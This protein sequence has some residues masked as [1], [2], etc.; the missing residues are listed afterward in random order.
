MEFNDDIDEEND[1]PQFLNFDNMS[2]PSK[3]GNNE[4]N[5]KNKLSLRMKLIIF[6]IIIIIIILI[7]LIIYFMQNPKECPSR[8]FLPDDSKSKCQQC[9]LK[10]CDKCFGTK[11]SN[12]CSSCISNFF[13]FYEN[14]ILKSCNP[15][16]IGKED[17][18]LA[19]DE[20]INKCAK[21]NIGYK[22]ENG[23]CILNYSFR[24]IYF[25]NSDKQVN[26][27]HSNYKDKIKEI[28]IDEKITNKEGTQR[29]NYGYH[30]VYILLD[31]NLITETSSMFSSSPDIEE[32]YFSSL[33]NNIDIKS[34][35]NMFS[36]CK[37]LTSIDFS[38][39]KIK[40]VTSLSGTFNGCSLLKNINISNIDISKVTSMSNMFSGCNKLEYIEFPKNETEEL[41]NI[42]QMFS[43]CSSLKSLELSNF[44]TKQATSFESLFKECNSLISLNISSFNTTKVSKMNEMFKD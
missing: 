24:A 26:L 38:N 40:N 42:Q 37:G 18:C 4:I 34:M 2:S 13:P 15:C 33:F 11:D 8:Y 20:E 41:N 22:L 36:G 43:G 29:L 28:I 14:N 10:N 12:L 31:M 16:D 25:A 32:V 35:N 7:V 17:K 19:C 5:V 9:S 1:L 39:F 27:I 3:K 23:K 30:I 21:C 6:S 44:D